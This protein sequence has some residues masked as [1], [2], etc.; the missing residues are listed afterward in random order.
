MLT[1]A[2]AERELY[3]RD[4]AAWLAQAAPRIAAVLPRYQGDDLVRTWSIL[5]RQAQRAVW[6]LLDEGERARVRAAMGAGSATTGGRHDR[7]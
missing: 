2:A 6:D 7:R 1:P 5:S 4:F 3:L